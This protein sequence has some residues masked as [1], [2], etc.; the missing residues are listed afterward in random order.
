[1]SRGLVRSESL[2]LVQDESLELVQAEDS[3]PIQDKSLEL[4][5]AE[6]S[7]PVQD[8]DQKPIPAA[9]CNQ[10]IPDAPVPSRM[11]PFASEHTGL[12]TN[13]QPSLRFYLSAPWPGNI[14]FALNNPDIIEPVLETS[15]KGPFREG[16]YRIN[17]ADSNFTLRP[18]IEYEWFIAIILDPEERS[19]D[20]LGSGTIR[21]V[22]PSDKLSK[23][24]A[25]YTEDKQH[26]AYA[27][28]GYWYDAVESL[29]SLIDAEP[30]NN[31]LRTQRSDLLRQVNLPLAAAYDS[32]M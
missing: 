30:G 3:E 13:S 4:V 9:D 11:S 5:Q 10:E 1:M 32:K 25:S 21:H 18:D 15:I 16:V 8:E 27:E 2:E 22:E 28:N 29:S 6:D 12:T 17:I 19:G 24:L 20:F 31:T 26:F 14:E 23:D 7:E